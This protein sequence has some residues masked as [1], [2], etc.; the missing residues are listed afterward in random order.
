MEFKDCFA[1]CI[2]R[3]IHNGDIQQMEELSQMLIESVEL[4]ESYD[5]EFYEDITYRLYEMAYGKT[6]N[7]E[8]AESIVHKMRPY[9]ERWSIEETRHFQNQNGLNNV[10]DVDF[11]IVLNS[12]YNDFRDVFGDEMTNYINYVLDFIQDED[13]KDGKVFLYYTTIPR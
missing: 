8:L 7:K 1:E 13:A 4:I 10:S 11:Y 12:A 9:G 6:L 3:I 2:E 5:K